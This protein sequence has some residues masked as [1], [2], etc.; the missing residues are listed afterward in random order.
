MFRNLIDCLLGHRWELLN[1]TQNYEEH[2]KVK[3]RLINNNIKFKTKIINNRIRVARNN[4]SSIGNTPNYYEI[5]VLADD[6][7][8]ANKIIN[9]K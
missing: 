4:I 3:N 8:K 6:L 2:L 9:N 1:L 5:Y 7:S